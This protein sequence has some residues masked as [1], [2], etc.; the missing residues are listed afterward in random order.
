MEGTQRA[1]KSPSSRCPENHKKPDRAKEMA[2]A[3]RMNT[4]DCFIIVVL[5]ESDICG[6]NGGEQAP[7][8]GRTAN[9]P[10]ARVAGDLRHLGR[11]NAQ[12][13]AEEPECRR[14]Q[15]GDPDKP[16]ASQ[17]LPF[18]AHLLM[19]PSVPTG[20]ITPPTADQIHQRDG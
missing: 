7:T 6:T 18:P 1:V 3:K 13:A 12:H 4:S 9:H 5:L 14:D 20:W 2:T 8:N 17:K 11:Q 19:R 10:Q 16:E 15:Q